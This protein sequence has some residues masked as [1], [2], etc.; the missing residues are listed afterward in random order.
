MALPGAIYGS[1]FDSLQITDS[2]NLFFDDQP[3]NVVDVQRAAIEY[4]WNL[5]S[6][7]CLPD[8]ITLHG[9]G[10]TGKTTLNCFNGGIT[11]SGLKKL[12]TAFTDDFK[13]RLSSSTEIG[14]GI[15]REI[16]LKII[17]NETASQRTGLYFFDF[18]MLLN[19]FGGLNFPENP[20]EATPE[21]LEQYA[22]YI[23]SDHIG[24]EPESGRLNLLK[25][26]FQDI[27][28]ERIYVITANPYAGAQYEIKGRVMNPNPYLIVFVGL[29]RVLLPSFV[30]EHLVCTVGLRKSAAI[31]RILESL[32]SRPKGGA[33]S[34]ARKTRSKARKTRSNARKTRRTRKTRSK[35]KTSRLSR[36]SR[37]LS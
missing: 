21:W 13:A 1:Q 27:G 8:N 17:A 33:R 22:K 16:I 10:A 20:A 32:E 2:T 28:P 29:L 4:K 19:Q 36:R 26:M 25:R 14:T 35:P 12:D 6:V 23:F 34:K 7:L 24:L 3:H 15:T 37:R 5:Q 11:Y 31:M 18:D 30:P 9:I